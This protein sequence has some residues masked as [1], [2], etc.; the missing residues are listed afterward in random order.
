MK[1]Y[2][3]TSSQSKILLT[4]RSNF[5]DTWFP[6]RVK[7]SS[8]DRSKLDALGEC[9]SN[10]EKKGNNV[11]AQKLKI[12]LGSR[13]TMTQQTNHFTGNSTSRP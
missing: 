6:C 5:S 8:L 1:Q 13:Q 12:V 2:D 11:S 4:V 9:K 7:K 3:H 10:E